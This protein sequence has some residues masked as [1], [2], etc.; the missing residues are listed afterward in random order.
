MNNR[1]FW[2]DNLRAMGIFLVVLEHTGRIGEF[3]IIDYIK[4]FYMPLFFF[5]SGL[6]VT[7]SFYEQKLMKIVKKLSQKIIIPYVFFALVSYSFWL[8][9]LR[10]FKEQNFDPLKHLVGIA[11]ATA[12][13]GWLSYNGA[14]WFFTS[15]FI[16]K[17]LFY[18]LFPFRHR[19]GFFLVI[20]ISLSFLGYLYAV[21]C[22]FRL[23]W[24]FGIS[25][26]GLVFFS[27]GYLFSSQVK[28][29][30]F[31]GHKWHVAVISLVLFII[32]SNINSRVEFY[33]G[34]FGNYFYFYVASFSGILTFSYLA[35]LIPYN[36]L[37]L[38]IGQNTLVIFSTHLLIIPLI[39]G[40]LVY[41]L[42]INE[43]IIEKGILI[44]IFYAIISIICTL[45]LSKLL[46][47]YMPQVLGKSGQGR[48]QKGE[49]TR[50]EAQRV[51]NL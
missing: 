46:N 39:T 51:M 10:H 42:A 49:A 41:V 48:S 6:F 33:R 47:R 16:V 8:F 18:F 27:V 31:F 14:L 28:N 43:H 38:S 4:S 12:S 24:N 13:E 29:G 30:S 32:F 9:L 20:V 21:F 37:I 7:N 34:D 35:K 45:S 19:K 1:I 17:L 5:I 15:L 25:I 23:P 26:T 11:Y 3:P 22:P 44:S 40:F 50:P 36:Q 2:I